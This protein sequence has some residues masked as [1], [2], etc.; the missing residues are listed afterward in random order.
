MAPTLLRRRDSILPTTAAALSLPSRAQPLTG[1]ASRTTAPPEPHP[2][3]GEILGGLGTAQRERCLGRCPEPALLSRWLTECGAGDLDEARR[4]LDGAGITSRH[5][6][7]EGD[8]RHGAHAPHCRSCAVLLAR[9]GVPSLAPAVPVLAAGGEPGGDPHGGP[10]AGAPW[11]VGTVDQALAAAGWRP[12]REHTVC[13][14][15][16]ADALTGHQSAHPHVL[17][18][19]AFETWA[20]LGEITLRPTGPGV[21]IAPSPVLVNPLAGLHWA[22]VL[23]SLGDALGTQLAPLGEELG[24]AGLVAVDREARLY[25][26]DHAGDWFLGQ[27]VI[28]GLA[29]LLTGTAPHRLEA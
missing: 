9:L 15:R 16:W 5:I 13:A 1:T 11:S 18:P 27:D 7:E 17:F 6:R 4:V 8:P 14:E 25:V 29:A 19:A 2:V 22:R 20:E 26:L 28:T 21:A 3:V 24:G 10:A 23:G 12:G